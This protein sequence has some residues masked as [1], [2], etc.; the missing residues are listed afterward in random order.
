MRVTTASNNPTEHHPWKGSFSVGKN[1]PV[2]WYFPQLRIWTE[3]SSDLFHLAPQC[4]SA[5]RMGAVVCCVGN[6]CVPFAAF[7]TRSGAGRFSTIFSDVIGRMILRR[8]ERRSANGPFA[9]HRRCLAGPIC[10]A[11]RYR[12][13]A[14]VSANGRAPKPIGR[15]SPIGRE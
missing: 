14:D 11:A 15:A 5:A 7:N 9:A 4:V 2:C 12:P 6:S 13:D 1:R 8:R 10:P 3:Q